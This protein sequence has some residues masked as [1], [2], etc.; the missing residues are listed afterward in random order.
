MSMDLEL[1]TAPTPYMFLTL[2]M[3]TPR[4]S[5]KW[6]TISGASPTRRTSETLQIST[7]SSAT[8]RCPRLTSSSAASLLPTPDSP[9][10]ITPMPNTSMSTP[11]RV[12]RGAS[13]APMNMDA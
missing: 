11:W 4:I 8:R 6:R 5:M 1:M 10:I 2:M 12:M 7:T 9:V 3:P 13:L